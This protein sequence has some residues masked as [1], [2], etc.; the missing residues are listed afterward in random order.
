MKEFQNT[1]QPDWDWW[2]ELWPDPTSVLRQLGISADQSVADV[3]SG[4]G[5]F[6]LPAAT[7]VDEAAVFAIDL[8]TTLLAELRSQAREQEVENVRT[9]RGDA[10]NVADLL[11]R[12][13]DVALLANTFHGIADKNAFATEIERALASRG[14]FIVVNWYPHP[15]EETSV[16]GQSRGPPTDLRQSPQ[17]TTDVV[18]P[19]GFEQRSFVELPPTTTG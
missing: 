11:P 1:G 18:E 3:C 2:R 6:T 10:R 15:R 9:V 8:D 14:R 16:T 17:A 5:Y 4:N 19:A 12:S 7:L 13:V